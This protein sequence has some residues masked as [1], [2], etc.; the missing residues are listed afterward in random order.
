M[1]DR[2]D[3]YL[4]VK[5][6]GGMGNRMLCAITGI[7]Y[8]ELTG[9]LTIVDWSD[10]TY[11]NDGSNSFSKFFSCSQT[12]PKSILP[13]NGDIFPAIWRNNLNRSISKMVRSKDPKTHDSIVLHRKFSVD[14]RKLDYN[15]EIV[16]FW[17]YMHRIRFLKRHFNHSN[18]GLAGLN[19]DEIIRKVLLEQ[20]K[21]NED[22][23]QRINDFMTE[24][25]SEKVIG[26]HI[27][28]SDRKTDLA[29]YEK[30][31]NRFL[32]ESPEAKIFLCTDS[33]DIV[34]DYSKRYKNVFCTPKWYPE[35][36]ASMHQNT[37]CPDRETNGIEALVD[38]YLLA[39][40]D[41]LIYSGVST[42]SR[43]SKLLSNTPGQRIVNID[44]FNPRIIL[45]NIIRELVA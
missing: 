5:A 36:D 6:K 1:V 3:K 31:L 32:K 8:G 28:Y 39:K 14:V 44:R 13:S 21:L 37:T 33:Q 9:R 38:M 29:K 43:I 26:I 42:F 11:S 15:E 12:H 18:N 22:I 23:N 20:M 40:C 24:N 41:Y 30:N 10:E 17:N 19:T 27:R 34:D 2:C 16:V 45:K 25:W 35:G 7:L 4:V